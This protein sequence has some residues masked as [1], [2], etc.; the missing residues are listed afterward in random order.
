MSVSFWQQLLPG[1]SRPIIDNL[2]GGMA[3]VDAG[4]EIP[5]CTLPA[6]ALSEIFKA[7]LKLSNASIMGFGGKDVGDIYLL[8]SFV[9]E[10]LRFPSMPVFVPHDTHNLQ[11]R[12]ILSASMFDRLE[13]NINFDNHR[14][15]WG[16]HRTQTSHLRQR[17][18]IARFMRTMIITLSFAVFSVSRLYP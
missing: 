10:E 14:S 11:L 6:A 5:V 8:K 2:Y 3:L 13:Y 7:E 17:R 15:G 18:Q 1:S 9:W 12:W 16:K 4:A